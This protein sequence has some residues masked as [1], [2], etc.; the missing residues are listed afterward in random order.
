VFQHQTDRGQPIQHMPKVR[1]LARQ[2]PGP[3]K[4]GPP[5]YGRRSDF[6]DMISAISTTGSLYPAVLEAQAKLQREHPAGYA[7]ALIA[8]EV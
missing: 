8:H 3:N 6:D 4:K 2:R 5:Y 1:L 7:L